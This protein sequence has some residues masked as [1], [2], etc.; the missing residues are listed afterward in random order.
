MDSQDTDPYH[1][2]KDPSWL[3][4]YSHI[5]FP[6]LNPQKTLIC[7]LFLYSW[8]LNNTGIGVL[9]LQKQWKIHICDFSGG[10][11]FKTPCFQCKEHRFNPCQET[12]IPQATRYGQKKKSTYNFT[13]GPPCLV[14]HTPGFNQPRIMYN[15]GTYLLKKIC[16]SGPLQF[17]SIFVVVVQSL[18]YV[19]LCDPMNC[20]MPGFSVHHQLLEFAQTHHVHWVNDAIQPSHPLLS[21]SHPAFNLSQHQGLFQW[22]SLCIRWPK[23][24]SFSFS[25]SP[26]NEYSGLISFRMD[27]FDL[28]AGQGTLKS[29]LQ[30][31]SSKASILWRSV[32]FMRLELSYPYMTTGKTIVLSRQTFVSKVISLLFNMLSIWVNCNFITSRTSYKWVMATHSSVLAWRIPGT[33]QPSRLPS[34]GSQ[35]V[36]H[37]WSDLAAAA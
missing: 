4:F 36:R 24:W 2:N 10:P 16:M 35:R 20:S 33:G 6:F 12:K 22:V 31:H 8:T 25:I 5:H 30:H 18:S 7:Y 37:D 21:P 15:C 1:H 11:M 34:M 19:Q 17:K 23:Y 28:L 13:I 26:S 32:F 29:L 9:T 14:F 3:P 27:W